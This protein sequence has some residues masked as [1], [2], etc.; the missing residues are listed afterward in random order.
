[1]DLNIV[2]VFNA[3][4]KAT[5]NFEKANNELYNSG[6]KSQFLSGLMFPV[7]NFISNVGYVGVAVAG[8]YLASTR[9]NNSWKHTKFYTI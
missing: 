6:W 7:L 9:N 5:K 8:G 4:K 2:K 1:M 3:E